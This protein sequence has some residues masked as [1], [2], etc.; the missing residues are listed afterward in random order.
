MT[1]GYVAVLANN[2]LSVLEKDYPGHRFVESVEI[3]RFWFEA[4][5]QAGR[6]EFQLELDRDDR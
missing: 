2:E 6:E 3:A 1:E 5:K 4:G